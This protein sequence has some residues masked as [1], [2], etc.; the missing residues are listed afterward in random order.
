MSFRSSNCDLPRFSASVT[1]E[2]ASKALRACTTRVRSAR[3]APPAAGPTGRRRRPVSVRVGSVTLN[4][5]NELTR[6]C[7]WKQETD[8]SL[9]SVK[10]DIG[11]LD[12]TVRGD[13]DRLYMR[14]GELI[15]TAYSK[16]SELRSVLEEQHK[17]TSR[18]P[19][20]SD[21]SF[22]QFM[23]EQ[24]DKLACLHHQGYV[25][26]LV[27]LTQMTSNHAVLSTES[28]RTLEQV[29]KMLLQHEESQGECDQQSEPGDDLLSSVA[30]KDNRAAFATRVLATERRLETLF[31]DSCLRLEK[32]TF[33]AGSQCNADDWAKPAPVDPASG[34]SA[35]ASRPDPLKMTA[36]GFLTALHSVVHS[37]SSL[38]RGFLSVSSES[39]SE[40]EA[41]ARWVASCAATLAAFGFELE[42]P[43]VTGAL[44]ALTAPALNAVHSQSDTAVLKSALAHLTSS[45]CLVADTLRPAIAKGFVLS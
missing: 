19:Y 25:G 33:D 17:V 34:A 37:F 35:S 1:S 27:C 36:R 28:R 12:Q 13:K 5:G 7:K 22:D 15:L 38:V 31:N 42:K 45:L 43:S 10:A 29:E 26:V 11:K 32:E 30:R 9:A 44:A 21:K 3:P 2:R 4:Q 20:A 41:V 39:Y 18:D 40:D 24:L 14:K 16:N 23:V 8:E 6:T